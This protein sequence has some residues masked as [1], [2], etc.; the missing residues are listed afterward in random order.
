MNSRTKALIIWPGLLACALVTVFF[1][2]QWH[3]RRAVEKANQNRALAQLRTV[4]LADA[5]TT[6]KHLALEQ[7]HERVDYSHVINDVNAEQEKL[8]A[9]P[10]VY[11]EYLNSVNAE[12]KKRGLL[13]PNCDESAVC[14]ENSIVGAAM[15]RGQAELLV[16]TTNRNDQRKVV[17]SI[18][19]SALDKHGWRYA[20]TLRNDSTVPA[21]V[22]SDGYFKLYN[23][24]AGTMLMFRQG[25]QTFLVGP[26]SHSG[27]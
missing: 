17:R 19:I 20:Y 6:V 9:Q 7:K 15:E 18:Q 12:A 5:K 3:A 22:K 1:A 2:A 26:M 25:A 4:V 8:K 23:I 27:S 14:L 16:L 10:Q 24:R 11:V 21:W 13:Q